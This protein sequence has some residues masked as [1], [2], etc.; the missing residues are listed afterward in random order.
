MTKNSSFPNWK[1]I[2]FHPIFPDENY[3]GIFKSYY[4]NGVKMITCTQAIREAFK[5]KDQIL[6]TLEVIDRIQK[7]YPG[8]WKGI[9]IKTHLIGCSINH[10][11]GKWYPTFQKFL[12]TIEPDKVRLFDLEKDSKF[13][14]AS[15]RG[16]KVQLVSVDWDQTER[17]APDDDLTVPKDLRKY[18][19]KNIAQLDPGLKLISDEDLDASREAAKI[20]ILAKDAL[21]NLVLVKL[22]GDRTP[23]STL[24][25][26][27]TA[28]ASIKNELGE[29]SLRGIIVAKNFDDEIILA[30]RKVPEV[31][32]VKYTVKYDFEAVGGSLVD[33]AEEA[34]GRG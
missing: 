25:Q 21:D 13:K 3:L 6:T 1:R 4:Q 14:E 19:R 10:K 30:A 17:T 2:V 32:L 8:K 5:D 33:P 29:K 18:L 31:S 34:V 9:T 7:K 11:S 15:D 24:G 16:L 28:M 20:D 22:K 12:Y 27:L 23:I 26:I